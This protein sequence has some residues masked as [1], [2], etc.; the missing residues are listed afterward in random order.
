MNCLKFIVALGF[1]VVNTLLHAQEMTIFGGVNFSN[2]IIRNQDGNYSKERGYQTRTGG[3]AGVQF[4]YPLSEV[5]AMEMGIVF[6]TKGFKVIQEFGSNKEFFGEENFYM[7]YLDFPVMVK[8]RKEIGQKTSLYVSAGPSYGIGV[9]GRLK[10]DI[11]SENE[12]L[13][14]NE[15]MPFGRDEEVHIIRRHDLGLQIGTGIDFERFRFGVFYN[16]G[17]INVSS[18]FRDETT[19]RNRVFGIHVGYHIKLKK[20]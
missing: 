1:L 19:A 4:S 7:L 2:L 11:A 9:G 10:F 3:H 16:Q 13:L 17:I 14:I 12:E 15:K 5:W 18:R 20:S 6:G 8:Y